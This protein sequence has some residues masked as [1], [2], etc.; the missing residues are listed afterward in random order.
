M[1][2][3]QLVGTPVSGRRVSDCNGT[4]GNRVLGLLVTGIVGNDVLGL[5]VGNL[6]GLCVVGN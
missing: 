2:L 5:T 1:T 4:A 3:Y 6:L